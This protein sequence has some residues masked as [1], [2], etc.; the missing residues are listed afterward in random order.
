MHFAP[1]FPAY[2]NGKK[3][4][5]ANFTGADRTPTLKQTNKTVIKRSNWHTPVITATHIL[6]RTM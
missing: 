5:E 3:L 2:I 6:Q 1:V 4:R